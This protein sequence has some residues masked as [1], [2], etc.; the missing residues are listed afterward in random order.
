MKAVWLTMFA[1]VAVGCG[2]DIDKKAADPANAQNG[3]TDGNNTVA[4]NNRNNTVAPN[5][6]N[7][8]VAPV[9][10]TTER[11]WSTCYTDEDGDG[12]GVDPQEIDAPCPQ[13]G[14]VWDGGDCDD[15][16]DQTHPDGLETCDG[17]DR[18]CDG[19]WRAAV[20]S[21]CPTIQTALDA[22][23][24]SGARGEV[25]VAP[26]T[27][28]ENLVFRGARVHLVGAGPTSTAID[29]SDQLE[30]TVRFVDDEGAD[31]GLEGFSITGGAGHDVGTGR[32]GGGIYIDGADPTLRDLVVRANHVDDDSGYGGGISLSRSSSL[33][34]RVDVVGNSA[35]YYGGGI[36]L[37]QSP[38][39]LRQV[40]IIDNEALYGGG[41]VIYF[42]EATFDAVIWA[43][44][45]GTFGGGVYIQGDAPRITNAVFAAN[46]AEEGGALGCS[47]GC[48][49]VLRNVS[50][51]DNEA[52]AGGAIF[53]ADGAPVVAYSNF[54][55]NG[56]NPFD[57]F[58]LG[59][60]PGNIAE[61]PGFVS[62]S[63]D[64][65]TW[66]LHLQA[67]SALI[68]AG[69]IGLMDPDGTR[70]DIGAYGGEYGEW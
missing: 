45:D 46:R 41:A 58:M 33:L 11:D 19:T 13:V 14:L 57:G 5:N 2:R 23:A 34:E 60:Q 67:S 9:N 24:A 63:G 37:S 65:R 3:Q 70:A 50:V 44:N 18:D 16:D 10:N 47:S 1:V 15:T 21:V 17:V 7:N 62:T 64:P 26:G 52:L 6:R 32:R 12:F 69:D 22:A 28:R 61:L 30:A 48:A 35:G 39:T 31:S 29:G 38:A 42:S 36:H 51:S 43:W 40:R 66:D 55:E 68:D 8:T 56:P 53:V 4:S 54:W 20:P 59:G 49:V 25:A 27:Y